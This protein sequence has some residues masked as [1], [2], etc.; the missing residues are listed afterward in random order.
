LDSNSWISDS[1]GVSTPPAGA[2]I[3]IETSVRS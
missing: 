1:S 3:A 2:V